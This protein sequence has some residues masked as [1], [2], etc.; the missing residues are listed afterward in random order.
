LRKRTLCVRGCLGR[1]KGVHQLKGGAGQEREYFG[2]REKCPIP[3]KKITGG[4]DLVERDMHLEN[5][6]KVRRVGKTRTA[7][8]A[9][10]EKE[11]APL[12]GTLRE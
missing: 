5:A 12:R 8:A 3:L 1:H 4:L 7:Q 9:L 2:E 6:K 11:K 10:P